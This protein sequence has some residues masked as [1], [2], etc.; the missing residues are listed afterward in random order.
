MNL[1]TAT[2]SQFVQRPRQP[3]PRGDL[4]P[5]EDTTCWTLAEL[6]DC[7]KVSHVTARTRIRQMVSTGELVEV[8][9]KKYLTVRGHIR[10]APAYKFME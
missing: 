7:W 10:T 5:W 4:L 8:S 6:T 1:I 9:S 2:L 3:I